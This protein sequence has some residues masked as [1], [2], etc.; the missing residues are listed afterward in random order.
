[1][2]FAALLLGIIYMVHIDY[3]AVNITY[4]DDC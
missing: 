3:V 1:M 4:W 2:L